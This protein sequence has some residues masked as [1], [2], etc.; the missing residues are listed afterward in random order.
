MFSPAL[1]WAPPDRADTVE[2]ERR[3]EPRKL[4]DEWV[5]RVFSWMRPATRTVRLSERFE[6]RRILR[7]GRALEVAPEAELVERARA[8]VPTMLTSGLKGRAF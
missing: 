6:T 4:S 1:P 3:P 5:L 2:P 8:A 7:L